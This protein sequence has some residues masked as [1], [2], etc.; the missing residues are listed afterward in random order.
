MHYRHGC[1]ELP[2]AYRLGELAGRGRGERGNFICVW[3]GEVYM[4]PHNVQSPP[5]SSG[6]NGASGR[7]LAGVISRHNGGV[8]PPSPLLVYEYDALNAAN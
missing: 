6:P 5:P 1:K 7:Q 4:P 3:G 2:T 8:G